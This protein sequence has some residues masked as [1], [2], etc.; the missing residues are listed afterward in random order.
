MTSS[1]VMAAGSMLQLLPRLLIACPK[2]DESK[3]QTVFGP[4]SSLRD[5]IENGQR[6]ELFISAN[7]TYTDALVKAEI[8]SRAAVLGLNPTVLVFRSEID[9]AD[10]KILQLLTDPCWQLGMSTI[11]LDPSIDEFEVLSKISGATKSDPQALVSRTRLITGGR[12]DPNAPKGRNQYGWIMETQEVDLLLTLQSNAIDAVADNPTLRCTQLPLSIRV[13][14]QFGVGIS[15]DACREINEL[16]DWLLSTEGKNVLE[17]NG[18][19]RS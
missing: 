6:C 18:L 9:L 13:I 5:K 2:V 12:E 10:N 7:S 19:E 4:S 11:G 15:V 8:F 17:Q 16:Y 1:V 3:F 14:G